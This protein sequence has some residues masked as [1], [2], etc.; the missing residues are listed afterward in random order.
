M[1]L[2]APLLIAL[3]CLTLTACGGVDPNSPMGKRQAIFK[4]M[5]KTSEDLGGMLR[6]RVAFDEARFI[7]GAAQLDQLSRTPWQHFPQ[8]RDEGDSRA[9]DDV[10]ARQ[11]TFQRMARDL[12]SA[13]AALVTASTATPLKS[14][15]LAAP[16]QRVEDSCKACHEE[17]RAY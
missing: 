2:K 10:W 9:K 12:E 3:A 7:S 4:D 1:N 16:M 15:D 6:G 5:L 13:T 8:A 17:F 14:D 11:E